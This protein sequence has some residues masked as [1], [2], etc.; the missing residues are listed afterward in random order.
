MYT[1]LANYSI[2]TAHYCQAVSVE[3]QH[4]M[5]SFYEMCAYL[6]NTV[7]FL[8]AGAHSEH[9]EYLHYK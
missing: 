7:I 4:F 5:H 2:L 8:I 3:V 1:S 6:L 9:S